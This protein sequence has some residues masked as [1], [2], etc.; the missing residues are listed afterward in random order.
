MKPT[1]KKLLLSRE[2][3]RPL[4]SATLAGVHGGMQNLPT[5][6][7][8]CTVSCQTVCSSCFDTDCCLVKPGD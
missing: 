8:F 3:L 7:C 2:T 1:K 6:T 4:A 5:R